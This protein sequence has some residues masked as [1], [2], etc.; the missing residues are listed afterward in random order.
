MEEP[1]TGEAGSLTS[2]MGGWC[3]VCTCMLY[4]VGLAMLRFF[5]LLWVSWEADGEGAREGPF[6][7][8]PVAEVDVASSEKNL[9][10]RRCTAGSL[11]QTAST[12]REMKLRVKR[13]GCR[14]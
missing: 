13:V 10:R 12:R 1:T 9:K 8:V 7:G 5:K 2:W 6:K 14:S 3:C 11:G 4:G